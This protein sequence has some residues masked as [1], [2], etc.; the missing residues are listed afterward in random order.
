MKGVHLAS[1][2][3]RSLALLMN[4]TQMV[5]ALSASPQIAAMRASL[6]RNSSVES[7]RARSNNLLPV[8]LS[9]RPRASCC[10]HIHVLQARW[11]GCSHRLPQCLVIG[12][13][14]NGVLLCVVFGAQAVLL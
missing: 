2:N 8:Q 6:R 10:A 5:P 12:H 14:G 11:A 7:A 9:L 3:G 4:A 1:S 13:N